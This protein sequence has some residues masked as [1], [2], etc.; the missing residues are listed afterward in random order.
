MKQNHE[1]HHGKDVPGGRTTSK[2]SQ[3]ESG[4]ELDEAINDIRSRAHHVGSVLE[5][6]LQAHPC[7]SGKDKQR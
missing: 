7:N 1:V 3:P 5:G 2:L 4:T 6:I